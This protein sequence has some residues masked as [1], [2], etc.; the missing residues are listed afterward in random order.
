[1]TTA[2]HLPSDV[3]ET[4]ITAQERVLMIL[5]VI[6][7]YG[8]PVSATELITRTGLS[9][10]TLYRQLALLRKWGFV[11]E[12]GSLYAPGAVSLQ[13]ALGFNET[14]VLSQYAQA[15][16]H[17]LSEQSQETVAVTVAMNRQAICISMIEAKQSLRC[18]FEKGRSVPLRV[19]ATARCLLAHLPDDELHHTLLLEF[20]HPVQRTAFQQQLDAIRVQGYAC[21]DSEVDAGVWGV[22]F[23]LLTIKGKLLGVLSLMAPSQRAADN[24][25]QLIMLTAEAAKRLQHRL[26]NI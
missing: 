3:A 16:L 10:S 26:H 7:Q 2:P 25:S 14:T 24:Q 21:S 6:A 19:G 13:L 11:M 18:S 8:R 1:M 9:K 15:D 17:W 5:K 4:S 23:P 22:S 20:P 12:T